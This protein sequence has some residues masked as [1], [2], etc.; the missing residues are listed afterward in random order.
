MRDGLTPAGR[1]ILINLRTLLNL[2]SRFVKTV[3]LLSAVRQ[4]N[5]ETSLPDLYSELLRMVR[6]WI[7]RY[8][9]IQNQGH[10][11]DID[12]DPAA[13]M[14][15]NEMRLTPFGESMLGQEDPELPMASAFPQL[16]CNGAWAHTGE[17]VTQPTQ[18]AVA[19]GTRPYQPEDYVPL[20]PRQRGKLL[21]FFPPH[22]L[23]EIVRALI[24]L[25]GHPRTALDSLM[26]FVLGPDF[27]TGGSI[28][29]DGSIKHLY[30]TGQG[31]L[32]V[33]S[34]VTLETG[35]KGGSSI[36]IRQIPY[37]ITKTRI[38][39]DVAGRMKSG[40]LGGIKDIRDHSTND[41]LLIEIEVR[42]GVNAQHLLQTLANESPLEHPIQFMMTAS[43][44]GS[45][46]P[47][48]LIKLMKAY[49]DHRRE[50][51]RLASGSRGDSVLTRDLK[52]WLEV[53]DKRRTQIISA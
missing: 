48:G 34:V 22:N 10:I 16:L 21:S 32:V 31:T 33:R 27:P 24:Y 39:E 45:D 1:M 40:N 26:E 42:R 47:I 17:V 38:I 9:L 11:G 43:R 25:L 8:P 51:L 52:K 35:V 44:T 30:E 36:V 6:P 18:D 53:P 50:V 14:K 15:C 19:L 46:R 49:L 41:D 28:L 12:G 23:E 37:G 29:G 13:G 5:P 7:C 4:R 3:I 2:G 20:D